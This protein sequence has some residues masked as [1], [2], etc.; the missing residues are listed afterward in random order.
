MSSHRKR[1]QP[2]PFLRIVREPSTLPPDAAVRGPQEVVEIMR[3]LLDAEEVE[4]VYVLLVDH[5]QHVRGIHLVSRGLA[6]TS[7]AHP[8]EVYRVAVMY[9]CAFIVL[10]HNHPTGDPTP[11]PADYQLTRVLVEAGKVV[12]IPLYDHIVIGRFGR[13]VS[14]AQLGVIE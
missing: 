9:G 13:F 10:V 14:M 3:P 4:C 1:L 2:P 6:D 7:L 8:R 11:S 12:G 5:A